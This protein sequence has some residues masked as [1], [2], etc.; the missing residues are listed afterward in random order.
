MSRKVPD[1]QLSEIHRLLDRRAVILRSRESDA[2]PEEAVSR[3]GCVTRRLPGER[4]PQ[5]SMGLRLVPLATLF[6]SDMPV[7]PPA[8][9]G[10]E[11]VALYA[12]RE[13]W[14]APDSPDCGF[15]IRTYLEGSAPLEVCHDASAELTPCVL[16]PETVE[17][18]M[19]LYPDCGGSDAAWA[20]IRKIE[21]T[22]GA[23]YNEDIAKDYGAAHKIG[24]YP[25]YIQDAPDD[26]PDGYEFVMQIVSDS[27]VGLNVGDCGNYY[28]YYNALQG[29]WCVRADFY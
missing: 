21:K 26:I 24:G 29:D 19:P 5:D 9:R 3:L 10:V 15:E 14:D 23:D 27:R 22:T 28:F 13:C 2:P 1:E 20:L 25:S 7:V 6:M 12:P 8:L 18:D 17:N 16:I 11:L 4:P